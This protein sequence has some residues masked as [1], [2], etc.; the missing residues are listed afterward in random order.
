MLININNIIKLELNYYLRARVIVAI[1][2]TAE[3]ILSTN[4][5]HWYVSKPSEESFSSSLNIF[6]INNDPFCKIDLK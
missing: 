5:T 4:A 1:R 6:L 2:L 3:P